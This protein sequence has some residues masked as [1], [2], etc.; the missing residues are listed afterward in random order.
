MLWSALQSTQLS[1][2]DTEVATGVM[3]SV[4]EVSASSETEEDKTT[5]EETKECDSKQV[6]DAEG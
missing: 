4:R 5:A 1:H 3:K 6:E 2:L